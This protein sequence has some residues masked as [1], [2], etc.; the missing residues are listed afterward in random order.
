MV[1]IFER[2]A[3][4]LI[5]EAVTMTAHDVASRVTK[6]DQVKFRKLLNIPFPRAHLADAPLPS[7]V[8]HCDYFWRSVCH[9]AQPATMKAELKSFGIEPQVRSGSWPCENSEA[10]CAR[11][12]ISE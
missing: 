5:C 9:V 1:W 3:A 11:R 10:P 2:S 12:R 8:E 6:C 7:L 4:R